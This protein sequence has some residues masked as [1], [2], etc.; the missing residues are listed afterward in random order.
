[1]SKDVAVEF[2][3][4]EGTEKLAHRL[5]RVAVAPRDDP[6]SLLVAPGSSL[7]TPSRDKFPMVTGSRDQPAPKPKAES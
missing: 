6:T 2:C 3:R 5:D 4:A 1:M 7:H